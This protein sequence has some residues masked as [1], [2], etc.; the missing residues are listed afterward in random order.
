M[1]L[2]YHHVLGHL[3]LMQ[4]HVFSILLPEMDSVTDNDAAITLKM[5][6]KV[7]MT[8]EKWLIV[9]Q[10]NVSTSNVIVIGEVNHLV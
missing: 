7:A 5:N 10:D 6:P 4:V 9:Y 3:G 8:T 1:N 2:S